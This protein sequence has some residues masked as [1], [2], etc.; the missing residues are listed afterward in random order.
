[1]SPST[2]QAPPEELPVPNSEQDQPYGPNNEDLPEQLQ[3]ALAFAIRKFA[4]QEVFLR[5]REVIRDRKNRFYERGYQ[6]IYADEATGGFIQGTPG[7]MLNVGGKQIQCPE[8]IGDY[9]IFQPYERIIQSVLTQNAPG[10]DFRPINPNLAEDMEAAQTAEGYRHM[11]DRSNDVKG[12]QKEIVRM[13]CLSA[14]TILW[15]R[16]EPNGPKWGYNDDGSPKQ[17]EISSVFGTLESKVPI[18][19][20]DLCESLYA[21]LFDDP[22]V[23]QAKAEYPAMADKIKAN[24]TSLAES[25]YERTARLGVLQGSRSLAQ[26]G[27]SF[28]HLVT[29]ARCWLRPAC[30]EGD[31]YNDILESDPSKTVKDALLELATCPENPV[32]TGLCVTF[33]GDVYVG[34][35]AESMDDSLT[36]LFPY[37]GDCMFRLAIMDP[38]QIVQDDFN[39]DMNY[40][41]E[42]WAFGAPSTWVNADDT[43]FDAITDQRADPYC[44]RQLK[45]RAGE[46][47]QDNLL[48]EQQPEL[49]ASFV[50]FLEM[51]QGPLPQF[52][53]ACPP[54]LYGEAMPDQKTA[55]GYHLAA[56]QAM[57]QQGVWFGVIQQGEANMYRQAALCAAKNPDH[58]EEIVIPGPEGGNMSLRLE[59]LRKGKFG[60]YP[61]EDSAFPESTQQKRSTLDGLITMATTN[62]A[63]G[64]QIMGSPDNWKLFNTIMGLPE[65]VIPEAEARDKQ[66]FEIELLLQQSPVPPSPEEEQ[67]AQIQHAAEAMANT[68]QGQPAAPFQP[69]QPKSSVPVQLLDFHAWEFAKCQE[70]LSSSARRQQDAEG[71]QAGVQN[72]ILH[73]M[74]HQ[75]MMA[76]LA[77]PPMAAPAPAPAPK[78][79]GPPGKPAPA[80]PTPPPANAAP[81]APM[82]MPTM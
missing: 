30:F 35:Y 48:R 80:K 4:G 41:R 79:G 20:K 1:L 33:V 54:S 28:S 52:M 2:E 69:P 49:P 43:E 22:D 50:K 60:A 55:S 36:V 23:L 67:Q 66:T 42:T 75:Q 44:F 57:G 70:W 29:R 40:G 12:I 53:L 32:P 74:E 39:D 63:I 82:P 61:D 5:R 47:M 77:P 24:M 6:H 46:K 31:C 59:R 51:I 11:F 78:P 65:I 81:S 62:P 72:V 14:R 19:K 58:S 56:S 17:M 27:D 73:A 8:Y 76:A 25:A 9:N 13:M 64:M 18:L 10:I 34:C 15:T 7:G 21:F 37:V 71:N 16:T 3:N 26:M 38:M 45:L 68:V